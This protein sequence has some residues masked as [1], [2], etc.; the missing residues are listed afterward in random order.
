MTLELSEE[1]RELQNSVRRFFEEQC[2]SEY[3]RR[4]FE[5]SAFHDGTL[6]QAIADLGLTPYFSEPEA[7][8]RDLGLIAFECGRALLPENL[9]EHT[10][11]GPFFFSNLLTS[12]GRA[13]VTK[14]LN[15]N[16]PA[17][18]TSG[19]SGVALVPPSCSENV[20]ID[21]RHSQPLSRISTTFSL[22]SGADIPNLLLFTH[23][24]SI[25]L[26]DLYTGKEQNCEVTESSCIDR[27][28]RRFD[29]KLSNVATLKLD[30]DVK[31]FFQ[32]QQCLKAN[33]L[34]GIMAKVVEV[35]VEYVKTR[36]QFD[37][38]IGGFQAVQHRLA[39]MH[40]QAEAARTLSDFAAW[41][42]DNSP[43]QLALAAQSAIVY[44]TENA[45]PVVEGA[46]Q[47]HGGIGFTWE[48]N[49]HFY[50]RRAKTIETLYKISPAS[51]I[52]TAAVSPV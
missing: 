16:F 27:S 15:R 49:L 45:A 5:G 29:M 35:T 17:E 43:D 39:D 23:Q 46:I 3:I 47:L 8:F 9:V 44:A 1:Q 48:H 10:F 20:K 22:V 33:E 24:Q 25:C 36:K 51:L 31:K 12:E 30:A 2:D 6:L 42:A 21:F 40:L 50:L 37:V 41:A 38:P 19:K 14:H 28:L 32:L 18:I 34:A 11:A 13:D 7:K 52:E 4:R 26:C